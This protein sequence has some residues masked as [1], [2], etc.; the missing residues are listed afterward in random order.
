MYTSLWLLVVIFGAV[1]AVA[2]IVFAF[3]K[4]D[5]TKSEVLW[6]ASVLCIPP[7]TP[8]A[9]SPYDGAEGFANVFVG[10][11][12]IHEKFN[13]ASYQLGLRNDGVV[14]WRNKEESDGDR[15]DDD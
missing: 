10:K 4:T 3:D 8:V 5:G 15:D 12:P 6:V 2:G 7:D 11:G 14:V 9:H 13:C 1:V